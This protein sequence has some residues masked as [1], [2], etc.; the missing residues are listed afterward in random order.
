MKQTTEETLQDVYEAAKEEIMK[1]SPILCT[2]IY[3]DG[4]RKEVTFNE[5]AE[6]IKMLAADPDGLTQ[7]QLEE[8]KEIIKLLLSV[9]EKKEPDGE[10][11]VPQ[12]LIEPLTMMLYYTIQCIDERSAPQLAPM[13]N[14]SAINFW[15][16]SLSGSKG[17]RV[18][19][20]SKRSHSEEVTATQH[21]DK[22]SYTRKSR[23]GTITIEFDQAS[24][25][26]GNSNKGFSKILLFSLQKM[27]EQNFSLRIGF[28]LQEL[29]DIGAYKTTD[30]ARRAVKD[31]FN[32][33]K[34]TTI[35]GSLKK[36]RR[37]I[38]ETGGILF[39]NYD[40][41]NGY[42][43]LSVNNEFNMEFIATY[44]TM[45]PRFAYGLKNNAFSLVW[46][47]FSLAR[48]N[49][50]SI[51]EHGYFTISLEAIRA[52]LGL[53]DVE[54]VANRKY[55]QY[56]IT[57]IE[58]AIEEIEEALQE[59]PEA[60]DYGFTITPRGINTKNID[61]W[62]H[63]YLEVGLNGDFAETFIQ[64]AEKEEKK[65]ARIERLKEKEL[66]KLIAKNEAENQE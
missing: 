1:K 23:S 13:P 58:E 42:V 50:K 52:A 43:T 66:A 24:N 22:V 34:L 26:L 14:G 35:S 30:S 63:G 20:K 47:V 15:I 12:N 40:I 7:K 59:V 44:F 36:G 9:D 8:I 38:R 46:Y 41:N 65:R 64:L 33:Q 2:L 37:T 18:A 31:F 62:L 51:K 4:Q 16:K 19:K 55:R 6:M 3:D 39:Y 53:P 61:E 28:P 45:F 49:V 29:V 21:G 60:N 48:Q 56:I 32:Q 25:Y 11:I 57:P 54:D 17:G 27:A 5:Y 10:T